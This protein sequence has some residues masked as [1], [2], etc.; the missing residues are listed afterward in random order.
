MLFKIQHS[1][2]YWTSG[3]YVLCKWGVIL[4]RHVKSLIISAVIPSDSTKQHVGGLEND[5][6]RAVVDTPANELHLC[7]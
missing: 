4:S 1:Y 3:I 6:N 5:T 7:L 2:L